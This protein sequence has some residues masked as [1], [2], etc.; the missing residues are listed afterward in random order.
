MTIPRKVNSYAPSTP[1]PVTP[2]HCRHCRIRMDLTRINPDIGG[3]VLRYFVCPN[4]H[5]TDCVR[6]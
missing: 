6:V 1:V 5:L 2:P 3:H 4:C